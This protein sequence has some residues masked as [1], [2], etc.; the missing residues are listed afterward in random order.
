MSEICRSYK[1]I[2]TMSRFFVISY[3]SRKFIRVKMIP[4]VFQKNSL[5][6]I[7]YM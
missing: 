5:T 1:L 4:K 2:S 7:L 3:H 6:K